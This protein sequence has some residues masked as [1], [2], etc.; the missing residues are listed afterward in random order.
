MTAQQ[1]LHR[2]EAVPFR[3]EVGALLKT[4]QI[5]DPAPFMDDI[6]HLVG[7]AEMVAR[8]KGLYKLAAVDALGDHAVAI[9][10]AAFTSRILRVN[11]D[12]LHRV[13]PL[14]A[15]CGVELEQWSQG[16]DDMIKQFWADAIKD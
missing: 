11:V 15:T 5:A 9:D 12:G 14:V 16:L 2:I 3:V 7:E 8:P 13:F 6:G 4:L 10:G 1:P